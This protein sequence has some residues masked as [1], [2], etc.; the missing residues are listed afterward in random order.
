[1]V[2]LRIMVVFLE[3]FAYSGLKLIIE[4]GWMGLGNVGLVLMIASSGAP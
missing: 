1:M 2:L 4:L 3:R